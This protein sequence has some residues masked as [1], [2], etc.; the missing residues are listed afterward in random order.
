MSVCAVLA[1]M[2]LLLLFE[3]LADLRLVVVVRDV[4]HLI[5]NLNG[6]LLDKKFQSVSD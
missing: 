3:V 1:E 6:K 5:L 2:T 4:E